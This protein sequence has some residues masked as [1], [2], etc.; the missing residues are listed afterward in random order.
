MEKHTGMV[1]KYG[2]MALFAMMENG[3]MINQFAKP[4]ASNN[5]IISRVYTIEVLT[6][7]RHLCTSVRNAS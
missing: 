5:E 7:F 3:Q 4:S 1:L 2:Q 6:D